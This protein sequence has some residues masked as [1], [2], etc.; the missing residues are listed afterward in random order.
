MTDKK[1]IITEKY[2]YLPEDVRKEVMKKEISVK[3][4]KSIAKIPNK[5]LRKEAIKIIKRQ[6][7]TKKYII[8][9]GI[10]IATGKKQPEKKELNLDKRIINQF[11]NI[12]KQVVMKMS[13][14]LVNSYCENTR[15]QL[16][17]IMRN[18]FLYLEKELIAEPSIKRKQLER[19]GKIIDITVGR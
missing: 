14:R 1:P 19:R 5:E 17:A 10:D 13:M 3:D 15:N 6:E 16:T 2:A 7:E 12:N 8:K 9:E 11:Y 4:A 18:V